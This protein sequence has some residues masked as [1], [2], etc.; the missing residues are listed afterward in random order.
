MN[1]DPSTKPLPDL[2]DPDW[3]PFWACLREHRLTAQQCSACGKLRFPPLPIC[4]ACLEE[5]S[6][7][8][9]VSE[10]GLVWSY[11]VYHRAFH[12]A[13]AD[14]VP[15]VVAIVENH[16]GLHFTGNIVGDRYGLAVG[17]P[18]TAVFDPVTPEVT[19]LN[20]R[21]SR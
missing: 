3:A 4:D 20:W 7:W 11:V 8:R 6:E 13:F 17:V 15:Y 12:P 1:P 19:L 21:L 14:E 2:S 18:V 5:A 10:N 9:E 16:D